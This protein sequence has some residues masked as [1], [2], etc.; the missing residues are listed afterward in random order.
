MRC[1]MGGWGN[2][3]GFVGRCS[4]SSLA[5]KPGD[6]V[7]GDAL[8]GGTQTCNACIGPV[9]PNSPDQDRKDGLPIGYNTHGLPEL[10]LKLGQRIGGISGP[11]ASVKVPL[12]VVGTTGFAASDFRDT[13][14]GT[15]DK[16]DMGLV[17][18]NAPF[19]T[20]VG[21]GG[22]FFPGT[23]PI[24]AACC[25]TGG[26]IQW[27][28]AAIGV[29]APGSQFNRVFDRGPGLDGIPGCM[30]DN[31][32][33]GNGALA[34][35][36]RLGKGNAGAKTDGFYATGKDD[37][38]TTFLVGASG[39]IPASN[40]RYGL[41]DATPAVVAHFEGPPYNYL[42]P[43][44][45]S[46][47]TIASFTIRDIKVIAPSNTDVLV[48]VNTSFCPLVGNTAVCS[49]PI[50]DADADGVP[51]DQDNCVFVANPRPL[52]TNPAFLTQRPWATLTG[53]QRDDDQDGWGN[54]CDADFPGTTQGGNV[55]SQD[56][57]AFRQSNGHSRDLL[58]CGLL[59]NVRCAVFDLDLNQ[60]TAAV[61]PAGN[62]NSADL[63]RFRQLNGSAASVPA[64]KCPTC[65]LAC[66]SGTSGAC[67]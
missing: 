15:F 5:C 40:N 55:N 34:C 66:T 47:N 8:C 31:P 60:N 63:G 51:D 41:R 49:P 42:N 28:P 21:I 17:D 59:H 25:D 35:D 27:S 48:K 9:D 3:P 16:A 22:T 6:P 52:D 54:V 30:N 44:P 57:G 1:K 56:L 18:P 64:N 38:A 14:A 46:V 36:Q 26:P 43:N 58:D 39:T 65:P 61:P 62:I 19:A 24:G 2:A 67:P 29:P 10:D 50:P 23:L 45:T 7:D 11:Q 13:L 37:Q 12:F 53:G 32:A 4:D 20:G 33:A